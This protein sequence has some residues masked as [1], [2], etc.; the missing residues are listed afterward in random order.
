MPL[1]YKRYTIVAGGSLSTSSANYIPVAY[2]GW[3]IT[4][5]ER[6][7]YALITDERYRTFEE[8]SAAA[9]AAAKAWVDSHAVDLD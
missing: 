8:A 4:S 7:S 6:G 3:D 5:T 1:L 2:I 9:F